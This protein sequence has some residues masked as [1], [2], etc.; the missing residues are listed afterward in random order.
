MLH[1]AK[2]EDPRFA[3]LT[4]MTA[5]LTSTPVAILDTECAKFNLKATYTVVEEREAS[6][7][8]PKLTLLRVVLSSAT[9]RLPLPLEGEEETVLIKP[10]IC[11][12]IGKVRRL[13]G[14]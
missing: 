1:N 9:S 11:E 2:N 7:Y 6:R 12:A 10:T 4:S 5:G 3:A 14:F 13:P 8:N